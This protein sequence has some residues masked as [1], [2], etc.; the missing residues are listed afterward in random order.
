MKEWFI[1]SHRFIKRDEDE[2]TGRYKHSGKD[3]H[4][5]GKRHLYCISG[6]RRNIRTGSFGLMKSDG[7]HRQ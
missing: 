2:K 1:R 6:A 3:F 4:G 7:E 5:M